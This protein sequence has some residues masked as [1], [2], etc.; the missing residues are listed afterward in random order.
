MTLAQTLEQRCAGVQHATLIAEILQPL[1]VE[2][3]L[4]RWMVPA[5]KEGQAKVIADV[6]APCRPVDTANVLT[7]IKNMLNKEPLKRVVYG[8][9]NYDDTNV[10]LLPQLY[11]H[12]GAY[13]LAGVH[14][15]KTGGVIDKDELARQTSY[16]IT[17]SLIKRGIAHLWNVHGN[18]RPLF[19]AG[20]GRYH[21][22]DYVDSKPQ[23]PY[24]EQLIALPAPPALRVAQAAS[25]QPI[26]HPQPVPTRFVQGELF[27]NTRIYN[28]GSTLPSKRR[29]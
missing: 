26:Q 4:Q 16:A 9:L 10:K 20:H 3:H 21:R 12:E 5:Y 24:A 19:G 11:V 7:Y 8:A 23:L 18:H 14:Q 1:R 6:L 13:L 25:P 29:F 28:H 2:V 22:K 27:S 17:L 15:L